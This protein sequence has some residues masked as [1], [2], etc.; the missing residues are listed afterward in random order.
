MTTPLTRDFANSSR[1]AKSAQ[2]KGGALH[3]VSFRVS[4]KEKARIKSLA[5]KRD[6]SVSQYVRSVALEDDMRVKTDPALQIEVAA[7][8]LGALGE[9]GVLTN[10]SLIADAAA[11]GALPVT[12][13]LEAELRSA[14]AL[15]LA[16]RSDLIHALGIK[17]QD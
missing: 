4:A 11:S 5:V 10:L 2:P 8:I 12:E 16:I 6:Q 14:C 3:P 15:V 9:S 17:P 1:T 7:K 13:E